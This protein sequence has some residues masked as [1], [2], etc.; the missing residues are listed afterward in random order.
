MPKPY[1][2]EWQWVKADMLYTVSFDRLH[3]PFDGKESDGKRIYD[4][5]TIAPDDLEKIQQCIKCGLGL[6]N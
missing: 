5:R 2:S 3:L 6:A 1:D 4:M